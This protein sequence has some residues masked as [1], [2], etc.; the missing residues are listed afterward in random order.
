MNGTNPIPMGQL[1]THLL[2]L[3]IPSLIMIFASIADSIKDNHIYGFINAV[4]P[5]G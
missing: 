2:P 5:F 1:Y 4:Q 3:N